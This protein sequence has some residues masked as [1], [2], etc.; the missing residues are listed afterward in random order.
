MALTLII[1]DPQ[2]ERC[3]GKEFT[4][5]VYQVNLGNL[6]IATV[7]QGVACRTR[8]TKYGT[9]HP[10]P[11]KIEK[12]WTIDGNAWDNQEFPTRKDAMMALEARLRNSLDEREARLAS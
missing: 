12:F 1:Q 11:T 10:I 9:T 6:P 2:V 4:L 3:G 8:W 5:T 7:R